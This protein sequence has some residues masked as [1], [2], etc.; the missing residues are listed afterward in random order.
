MTT[1]EWQALLAKDHPVWKVA[2]ALI[3]VVGLAI[4]VIHGSTHL[5]DGAGVVGAGVGGWL[6]NSLFG[7]KSA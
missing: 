5:S 4:L 7:G 1:P 3:A 2:Q 6:L